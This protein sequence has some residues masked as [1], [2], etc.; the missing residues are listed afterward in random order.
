MSF[1]SWPSSHHS[2]WGF[3]LLING[4]SRLNFSILTSE[5][6]SLAPKTLGEV[7][8]GPIQAILR[9]S[10]LRDFS[11]KSTFRRVSE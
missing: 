1:R 3:Q 10:K 11:A 9:K 5:I 6:D 8:F 7:H 2:C 4:G